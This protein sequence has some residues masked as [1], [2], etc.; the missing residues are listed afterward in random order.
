MWRNILPQA[1]YQIVIMIIL[2]FGAQAMYFDE[3]FDIVTSDLR[4]KD[5]NLPE[6]RLR[7]DTLC[8]HTFMLMNIINMINCRVVN[9][10]EDNVFKTIFDNGMF[11]IIFILE[12]VVQNGLVFLAAIEAPPFN[13]IGILSGTAGMTWQMHLSA[14]IFGLAVLGIRPLTNRIPLEKFI[15][16]QDAIDLETKNTNANCITKWGDRAT[17][18]YKRMTGD[19]GE[20]GEEE[21]FDDKKIKKGK[22]DAKNV[23]SADGRELQAITLDKD[24]AP[25]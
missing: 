2:M 8:F 17:S 13:V 6:G 10:N 23:S 7:K 21:N 14:W 22:K 15:L 19:V 11:W 12:M 3:P 1:L 24:E 5:S 16:I 20:E 4:D 18:D 9:E 25:G